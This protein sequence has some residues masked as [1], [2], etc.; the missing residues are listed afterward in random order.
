[1]S[2]FK[3]L[4]LPLNLRLVTFGLLLYV[5]FLAL[6]FPAERAYAYWK[7][8]E[9][10]RQNIA[11]GG[12]SGTVWSGRANVAVID[13]TRLEA[14]EW[15]LRPW[16]VLGGQVALSWRFNVEDGFAEGVTALSMD[17][18]IVLPSLEAR[19]PMALLARLAQASVLRPAGLLSL[20]VQNLRWDGVSLVSATGRAVWNG[21][22]VSLLKP[23][24]LGDLS[25]DLETTAGEVRGLLSDAGGPLS[26]DGLLALDAEGNYQ[27]SGS[28]AS[29]GNAPE[30]KQALR[31]LGRAGSDG[32]VVVNYSGSLAK[33]G[34]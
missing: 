26:L 6:N 31:S 5:G 17:G 8:S 2:R 3:G 25:L 15:S 22:E 30:L 20:N 4:R 9:L 32:K 12:I 27:F 1:M 7:G 24:P 19:L 29:R 23:L 33:L 10:A 34:F 11:L 13:G 18:S 16:A 28:L 21:A 14:L